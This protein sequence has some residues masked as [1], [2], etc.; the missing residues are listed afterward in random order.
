MKYTRYPGAKK[1][2]AVQE[3]LVLFG[4][5]AH[6]HKINSRV[7]WYVVREGG[8]NDRIGKYTER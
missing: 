2:A 4:E 8:R 7:N 3:T 6:A 5:S 1:V